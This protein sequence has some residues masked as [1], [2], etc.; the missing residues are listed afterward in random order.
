MNND[1]LCARTTTENE[2]LSTLVVMI[3]TARYNFER[4]YAIRST[5]GS[6]RRY[7][8][9]NIHLIFLLGIDPNS[10]PKSYSENRLWSES[11]DHGDMIMGNFVDSY[12]NLTYKQLMG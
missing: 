4:R 1:S 5:W 3:H 7:R 2:K 9:W 11:R 10:D 6:I 12:H 8:E